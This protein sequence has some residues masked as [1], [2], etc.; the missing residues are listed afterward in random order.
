MARLKFEESALADLE[1]LTDFL[2][3]HDP[4]VAGQ[5]ASLIFEATA[6]LEK[7]PMI[8]RA[9]ENGFRELVISRGRSGYVALYDFDERK[10]LIVVLSI[11]HQR[12]IGFPEQQ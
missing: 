11:R 7:H 2:V 5:T 1:R 12:E 8:G 9:V 6:I 4:R 10:D 3:E